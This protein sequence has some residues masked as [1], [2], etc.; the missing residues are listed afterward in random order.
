MYIK[1]DSASPRATES[2]RSAQE[3]A[4]LSPALPMDQEGQWNLAYNMTG[5]AG[6]KQDI[7]LFTLHNLCKILFDLFTTKKST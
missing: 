1:R 2:G 4:G 5:R 6:W 7:L 3:M